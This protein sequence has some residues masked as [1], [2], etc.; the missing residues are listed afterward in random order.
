VLQLICVFVRRGEV[1]GILRKELLDG[2][3]GADFLP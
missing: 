2:E 1:G 3:D